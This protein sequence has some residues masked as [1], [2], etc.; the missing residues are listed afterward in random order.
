M[1]PTPPPALAELPSMTSARLARLLAGRR[2]EEAWRAVAAGEE[3]AG[4]ARAAPEAW[5]LGRQAGPRRRG[6]R[7]ADE[8]SC[9]REVVAS[10]DG[11]GLWSRYLQAGVR[12]DVLGRGGYPAAVAGD[13]DPPPVLFSVGDL[14]ALRAPRAAL[15]GDTFRVP[16]RT[17]RGGGAG[18]GSRERRG[19]G[20]LGSGEGDRLLCPRGSARGLGGEARGSRGNRPRHA[21]PGLQRVRLVEG[22]RAGAAPRGV[23]PR[24]EARGV[25]LP[26]PEQ[27]YR[28]DLAGRRRGR[29]P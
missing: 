14:Q 15:V 20:D 13:P 26:A 27:D 24:V 23:A 28:G 2:A 3:V 6:R 19:R 29:V 7:L 17:G 25:A 16:L 10:L 11:H 5:P 12:V 8:A 18:Q 22:S 4:P 1:R 9:W 21:V